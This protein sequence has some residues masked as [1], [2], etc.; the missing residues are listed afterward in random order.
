ME[1]IILSSIFPSQGLQI[2]AIAVILQ[3]GRMLNLSVLLDTEFIS[4]NI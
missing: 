4:L 2:C 1:I 3:Y